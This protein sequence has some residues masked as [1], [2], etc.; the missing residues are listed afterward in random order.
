MTNYTLVGKKAV[1]L[2][3]PQKQYD[4]NLV[5]LTGTGNLY[6]SNQAGVSPTTYDGVMTTTGVI[7]RLPDAETW[8]CTDDGQTISANWSTD[9]TVLTPGE[10]SLSPG[11]SI[12]INGTVPISVA[13]PVNVIPQNSAFPILNVSNVPSTY[14][15]TLTNLTGYGTLAL[16]VYGGSAQNPGTHVFVGNL[17]WEDLLGNVIATE[18]VVWDF[19]GGFTMQLPVKGPVLVINLNSYASIVIG[20][21]IQSVIV[22]GLTSILPYSYRHYYNGSPPFFTAGTLNGYGGSNDR[23][24][25]YA[26]YTESLTTLSRL[27]IDSH[28]GPAQLWLNIVT[29]NTGGQ[30]SIQTLAPDPGSA[31]ITETAARVFVSS[32]TTALFGAQSLILPN[33]PLMAQITGTVTP[34]RVAFSISAANQ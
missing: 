26:D 8:V 13:T 34:G 6:Y 30:F 18:E 28:G 4:G 25:I 14:S 32:M 5:I 24:G 31:F 23:G 20:V 17:M 27:F 9:G 12:N 22:E 15:V 2:P 21:N 29:V 1:N 33:A 10:V 3:N 16:R 7:T 19:S 11:T